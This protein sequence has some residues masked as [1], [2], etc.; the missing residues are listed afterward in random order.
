MLAARGPNWQDAE[1]PDNRYLDVQTAALGK[2]IVAVSASIDWL[3]HLA[4][5]DQGKLRWST[6]TDPSAPGCWRGAPERPCAGTAI[7]PLSA[8]SGGGPRFYVVADYAQVAGGTRGHQLSLWQWKDGKAELFYQND[9]AT[10]GDAPQGAT[11]SGDEINI[12]SKWRW[13]N[14][15]VC[16]ACEGRQLVH[17]VRV[18]ATGTQDLGLTSL[19]PELDAIDALLNKYPTKDIATPQ[20]AALLKKSWHGN[21]FIIDPPVVGE[22]SA[23]VAPEDLPA[24]TFRFSPGPAKRITAID[25]GPCH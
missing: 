17:Q 5:L 11:V 21:I 20:I 15:S 13:S 14:I 23:C 3:G 18:T 2:D 25:P 9:F 6:S 7:G 1:K 10:A 4:I 12:T 24:L 16:G 22:H 19:T 8:T